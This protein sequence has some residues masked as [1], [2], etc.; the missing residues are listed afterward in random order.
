MGIMMVTSLN[1]YTKNM[2]MA[3]KWQKRQEDGDY[4]P[5]S[6]S[7][8]DKSFQ[9]QLDELRYPE[10]DRSVKMEADIEIK[11]TAGKKLSGEEMAYIKGHN[12]GLYQKVK[13]IERER[14]TYEKA[15]ASCKTKEEVEQLKADYAEVAVDRINAIRNN[16]GISIEK[17][18]ELLK[19]EHFRG[20]ALDDVMH[21]FTDS[22]DYKDLPAETERQKDEMDIEEDKKANFGQ[23]MAFYQDKKARQEK[24]AKEAAEYEVTKKE[25]DE[26]KKNFLPEE[27]KDDACEEGSIMKAIL[28]EEARWAKEDEENAA[29]SQKMNGAQTEETLEGSKTRQAKA[30]YLAAQAYMPQIQTPMIDVRK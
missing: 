17:K 19:M 6:T 12:R 22:S 14:E 27:S 10:Y 18:K 21:E 28:D 5:N 26:E 30:A 20:A 7:S 25:T 13:I 9:K 29:A 4:T 23:N 3:M 11:L 24:A 16:S 1:S 2:Q 8:A 15:L